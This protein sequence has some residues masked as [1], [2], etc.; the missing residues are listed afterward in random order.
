MKMNFACNNKLA[1]D[2]YTYQNLRSLLIN[3]NNQYKSLLKILK[4]YT[5]CSLKKERMQKQYSNL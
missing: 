1:S 3:N 5:Q 4:S 2:K